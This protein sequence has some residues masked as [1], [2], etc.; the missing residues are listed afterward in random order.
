M[1]TTIID[2][3]TL[4]ENRMNPRWAIVDCRFRLD[5]KNN[6][7]ER[8]LESHIPGAVYAHVD[9]DLADPPT[10]E[11]GRH[12]LPDLDTF[13]ATLGKWG[14]GNDTQV[15]VYDDM[16]G[17]FAARLWWMLRY[18]GHS[19]VAV[20]DGGWQAWVKAEY[21][22]HSG[23]EQHLPTVFTGEPNSAMVA[24]MAEVE[25]LI[26]KGNGEKLIDSRDP[27][28]YRGEL[29]PI[30]PRAGHIPGAKN[31]FF[32]TNL[33]TTQHFRPAE[34]LRTMFNDLLGDQPAEEAI[35][36]CGSGVTACQNLLALSIAGLEGARLF[37]SSWSGWSSNPHR[38]IETGERTSIE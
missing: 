38:P 2:V 15:V 17:A 10:A 22:T 6:G 14:I 12:P 11:L 3:T 33:D 37:T 13:R 21:V 23:E 28:R 7:R 31:H 25:Q 18:L 30:D 27:K 19:A 1:Y 9:E 24:T 8:Y 5:N 20:L 34:K 32:G 4:H 16:G 35:V 29:E 36:Y 26:E